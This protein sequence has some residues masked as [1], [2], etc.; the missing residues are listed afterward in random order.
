MQLEK[1][2]H[3]VVLLDDVSASFERKLLSA[4]VG[5]ILIS[6]VDQRQE[7]VCSYRSQLLFACWTATPLF[8]PPS[9]RRSLLS[10]TGK[11]FGCVCFGTV[12]KS[13]G[14][15]R[16]IELHPGPDSLG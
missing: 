1:D 7:S 3:S 15:G 6:F 10:N 2:S 12:F 8:V 14:T 5:Q 4:G 16:A 13:A 11:F 9:Q